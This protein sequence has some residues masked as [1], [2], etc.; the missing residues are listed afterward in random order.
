MMAMVVL[1]I[2]KTMTTTIRITVVTTLAQKNGSLLLFWNEIR[3]RTAPTP[4]FAH[5]ERLPGASPLLPP[6]REGPLS[7]R[8]SASAG[9]NRLAQL[10]T[11]EPQPTA[12]AGRRQELGPDEEGAHQSDPEG[13]IRKDEGR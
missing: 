6:Y 4:S 7:L 5:Q 1:S 11:L 8:R 9:A 13:Q 2:A 12:G 10:A 3:S